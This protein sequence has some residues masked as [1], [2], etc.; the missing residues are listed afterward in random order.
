MENVDAD[1]NAGSGVFVGAVGN[2]DSENLSAESNT[3]S[4]ADISAGGYVSLVGLNVFS[5]NQGS[6]LYA[7]STGGSLYAENINSSDNDADGAVLIGSDSVTLAGSNIFDGNGLSGGTVE[8]TNS[9]VDAEDISA[10]GNGTF[11]AS[12][13][14]GTDVTLNLAY[15]DGNDGTGLYVESGGTITLTDITSVNNGAGGVFGNGAEVYG[16]GD[17]SLLGVNEF[18][19]NHNHGFLSDVGGNV[20]AENIT[21]TGNGTGGYGPGA[22]FIT[23]GT[24]SLTGTNVFS[25]NSADGL[26]VDA[27]GN[28]SIL[29]IDSTNNGISGILLITNGDA[30]VECGLVTNNSGLQID[31]TMSGTLTLT[32]LD[33]GG[34]PFENVGV[35]DS[36][37]VLI[38]NNCFTYP[39]YYD[40]GPDPVHSG[41]G[42][43]ATIYPDD[44]PFRVKYVTA[45]GGQ[46]VGLDC[47]TYSATYI[48]LENGDGAIIPCPIIGSAQL[49]SLEALKLF[50]PL[51]T[52]VD[53]VSGM[54]LMITDDG[55]IF[56]TLDQPDIVWFVNK[57]TVESGGYEAAYWNGNEWVDVTDQIPPFLTIFFQVPEEMKGQD[58]AI[59]FW[60]GTNWV[61]LE[62]GEHLGKGRI[63]SGLGYAADGEQFQANLNFIGTF[64]LVKK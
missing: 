19:G 57:N 10:S 28:I 37:L 36:Q 48:L 25:M 12:L 9:F 46:P 16:S 45:V 50:K 23:S 54:D 62:N 34:N 40:L 3:L 1:N 64:V 7:E 2:I 55:Q 26:I 47:G 13:T 38:S 20:L 61:E 58:L 5:T 18:S 44:P 32:G 15:L 52:K 14:A 41:S 21:A 31:T 30:N 11:G 56:R 35:D 27:A 6:G 59:L 51:P 49:D 53:F 60:D 4:G 8:S 29:N 42:S 24:F 17:L 43:H 33:F 22:E 63:V 39:D